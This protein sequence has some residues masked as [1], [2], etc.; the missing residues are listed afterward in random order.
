MA[1]AKA[2]MHALMAAGQA[3]A[4]SWRSLVEDAIGALHLLHVLIDYRAL[5]TRTAAPA[6]CLLTQFYVP[7]SSPAVLMPPATCCASAYERE[8]QA[9]KR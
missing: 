1:M 9:T 6:P 4:A 2:G 3:E 7:R 8:R 5:Q